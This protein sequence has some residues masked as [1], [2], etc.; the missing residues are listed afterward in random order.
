MNGDR[1]V[2]FG[3]LGFGDWAAW[4]ARAIAELPETELSAVAERDPRRRGA[5]AREFGVRTYAD[6]EELLAEE[7][8][9]EVVDVVL[10]N[11]LHGQAAT[12]ALGAGKNVLVEKPLGLSVE[13]CDQ[14]LAALRRARSRGREPVLAVGFELRLS[15]VWGQVK[16][17]VAVGE[18]GRLRATHL[19]VF[20]A[21]PQ[22]GAGG[23]R[24]RPELV[25][26]W[27]LDAPIHYFDL[28]RWYMADLG[29]PTRL[30]AAAAGG[31]ERALVENFAATVEFRQGYAQLAYS[32]AGFGYAISARV[33]GD[34]GAIEARWERTPAGKGRGQ[35]AVGAGDSW[36]EVPIEGEV[37]ETLDV[38]AEVR[39]VARAV[40]LGEPVAADGVAGRQA[41]CMCLAAERAMDRGLP[42]ELTTGGQ[43]EGRDG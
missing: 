13:E 35:V 21:A 24:L 31:G 11:Y 32:V 15:P 23:W 17:L 27:L 38:R 36:R 42:V 1:P 39:Q 16:R 7:E 4:H 37:D 12:A 20:R 33:M 2:R 34:R 40:R 6:W 41:V 30:H 3:L 10:P 43:T 14:V 8:G 19:E 9:V 29:E 22:T 25:G 26:S 18:V 5:A 28:M